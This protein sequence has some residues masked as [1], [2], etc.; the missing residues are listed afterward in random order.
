VVFTNLIILTIWS[1]ADPLS[2]SFVVVDE[3]ALTGYY[4]CTSHHMLTW[5]LLELMFFLSLLLFGI[6]VIYNTWSFQR[7]TLLVETRWVLLALYN[8]VLNIVAVLPIL[9]LTNIT[10]KVLALILVAS[11][12]MSGASIICAVLL[13]RILQKLDSSKSEGG[14]ANGDSIRSPTHANSRK[15]SRKEREKEMS[16]TPEDE[17]AKRLEE[18]LPLTNRNGQTELELGSYPAQSPRSRDT[19]TESTQF[20]SHSP[21]SREPIAETSEGDV[22]PLPT[23]KK[24]SPDTS[25]SKPRKI[26]AS[27]SGME[28]E[29]ELLHDMDGTSGGD[30]NYMYVT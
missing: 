5:T 8:V 18:P 21:L 15:D 24:S 23:R 27:T 1:A 28:S 16:R 10:E 4:T 22:S 26:E 3:E 7:Q 14:T 11:I 25:P 19:I 13:P 6:Y 9:V 20:V 17:L 29:A 30:R 2:P 12:D